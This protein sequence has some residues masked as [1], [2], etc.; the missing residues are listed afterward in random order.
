MPFGLFS[1]IRKKIAWIWNPK[2][3]VKFTLSIIQF[4]QT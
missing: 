3:H 1:N 4:L 2:N